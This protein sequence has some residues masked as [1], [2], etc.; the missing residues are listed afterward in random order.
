MAKIQAAVVQRP[1]ALPPSGAPATGALP[2]E[3]AARRRELQRR[4]NLASG[5]VSDIADFEAQ[6][7]A[8][9]RSRIAFEAAAEEQMQKSMMRTANQVKI[10]GERTRGRM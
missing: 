2:P 1:R 10:E 6:Q 4:R 8:V 3:E 5:V 9:A 7:A